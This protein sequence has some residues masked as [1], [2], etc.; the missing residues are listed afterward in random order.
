MNADP[1]LRERLDRAA[2]S[3]VVDVQGRLERIRLV[4]IRRDRGRRIRTLAVAAAVGVVAVV[5]VWQLRLADRGSSTLTGGLPIG[6]IAFLGA[7]GDHRALFDLDVASGV[8][9]ALSSER[10][11][12][13][14]A[15]WSPDGSRLATIEE[16]P[17]PRYALVVSEADGSRPVTIA[18][19]DATGA[20]GPDLIDVSWSP[21]GSRIAYS[22]RTVEDGVARRTIIIVNADGSGRPTVLDGLWTS[23]SWSPDGERLLVLG[24]PHEGHEGRF[25]LYTIRLDGSDPVQLT[26]DE[27]TEHEPSW[28]SDGSQIVFAMGADEVS[29]DVYV[30][31][32]DGSDVRRLT[33]PD[34]I[35]LLPVW[36]PDGQWIA[37]ASDRDATA[38]QRAANRSGETAFSGLSLY[39]MRADG[40]G[41][42]EVLGGDAV[43]P[44]SWRASSAG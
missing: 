2:T 44:V 35:D 21:D 36:S 18:E 11:P 12:V 22:G 31:D 28:S 15:A 23:V 3:V 25:D 32:A 24:F 7:Q 40:S 1:E 39:V 9:V 8:V 6:R 5:V 13:L 43:L 34:D 27:V 17:G 19:E 37:F 10:T 41:I 30:M 42:R 20:V 29:Q 14:W 4:A 16:R 26:D 33:D 38:E